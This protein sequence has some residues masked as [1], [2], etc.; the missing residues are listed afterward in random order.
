MKDPN[1]GKVRY[2]FK[3]V[4]GIYDFAFRSF[5]LELIPKVTFVFN[6]L[7]YRVDYWKGLSRNFGV[8]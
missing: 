2:L 7:S 1:A 6:S 8:F 3:A 4:L 5:P